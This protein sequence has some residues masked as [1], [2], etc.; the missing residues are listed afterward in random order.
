[1][2]RCFD[3]K[4]PYAEDQSLPPAGWKYKTVIS[5]LKKAKE[6]GVVVCVCVPHKTN[7]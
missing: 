6:D 4:P 1:V 2:E 3:L 5:G 7:K